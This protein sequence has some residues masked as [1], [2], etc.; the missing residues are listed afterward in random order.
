[1]GIVLIECAVLAF[2]RGRCPFSAVAA[3]YTDNK[4]DG[5]D[6]HP[7]GWVARYNSISFGSLFAAGSPI[8]LFYWRSCVAMPA[9]PMVRVAAATSKNAPTTGQRTTHW[10]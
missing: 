1:M 5:F 7:P 10:R 2:N 6:I 4:D 8:D 3:R 9:E